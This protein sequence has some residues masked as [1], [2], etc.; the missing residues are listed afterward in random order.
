VWLQVTG[1]RMRTRYF[2][3]LLFN[4]TDSAVHHAD[5]AHFPLRS[6]TTGGQ[7]TYQFNKQ[8]I[9]DVDSKG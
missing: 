4:Y 5:P 6:A 9:V 3:A 2:D 8:G 1:Q 7:M